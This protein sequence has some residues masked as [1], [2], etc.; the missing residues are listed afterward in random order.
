MAS[1]RTAD[2]P[3]TPPTLWDPVVRLTHWGIAAAVI[4]NALLTGGGS[5]LHVTIGWAAMALLLMRL[6]WGGLAQARRGSRPFRR[7]RWPLLPICA[8][9]SN[10]ESRANIPRTTLRGRL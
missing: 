6:V 7:I 10:P 8:A 9:F 3:A 1:P 4:A 2:R 5:L